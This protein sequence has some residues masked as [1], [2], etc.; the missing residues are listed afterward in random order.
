MF[1]YDKIDSNLIVP[2]H[3]SLKMKRVYLTGSRG[4]AVLCFVPMMAHMAWHKAFDVERD[5][6]NQLHEAQFWKPAQS[7]RHVVTFGTF[8]ASSRKVEHKHHKKF[9]TALAALAPSWRGLSGCRRSS[10]Q[11]L[12]SAPRGVV[13]WEKWNL[14]REPDYGGQA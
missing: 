5:E 10:A 3:K 12:H 4:C 14:R 8:D 1:D 6:Y 9:I 2:E 13:K 11:Q 7:S